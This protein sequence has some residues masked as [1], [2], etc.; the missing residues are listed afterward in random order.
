MAVNIRRATVQ[1]AGA[2]RAICAQIWEGD[3]Y[4]PTVLDQWLNDPEGEFCVVEVDGEIGALGKLT[5]IPPGDG[6]LE[7]LRGNPAYKGRGLAKQ[8]TA[9]LIDRA[10]ERGLRSLRLS[11]Y[12]DN[13]ESRHIIASYGFHEIGRFVYLEH[14]ADCTASGAARR[15]TPAETE[16]LWGRIV[17]SRAIRYAGGFMSHGWLFFT[18]SESWFAQ[19]VESGEVW[20]AQSGAIGSFNTDDHSEGL[21]QLNLLDEGNGGFTDL[22][23]HAVRHAADRGFK[24]LFCN[25]PAD[26]A[27]VDVLLRAGFY[28]FDDSKT[29]GYTFLLARDI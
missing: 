3:D 28:Q 18:I 15:V 12:Q 17:Q 4:I 9:Y 21:L 24:M 27:M 20:I 29:V 7:G 19:Q 11:T 22:L 14:P 23:A 26:D 16:E 13:L 5:V 10:R 6:W 25:C 1:D 2:I 8:L